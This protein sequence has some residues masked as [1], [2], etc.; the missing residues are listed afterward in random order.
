MFGGDPQ[1]M[2]DPFQH[3]AKHAKPVIEG[4]GMQFIHVIQIHGNQSL[5]RLFIQIFDRNRMIARIAFAPAGSGEDISPSAQ[6][7]Q[8]T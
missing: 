8:C 6:T 2:V 4:D 7:F 5:S 3:N 1:D